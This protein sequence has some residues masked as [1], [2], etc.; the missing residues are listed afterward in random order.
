MNTEN[1]DEPITTELNNTVSGAIDESVIIQEPNIS[2]ITIIDDSADEGE[3]VD[4]SDEE[5]MQPQK[6]GDNADTL[7]KKR[8]IPIKKQLE[9]TTEAV[10]II[11]S[12]DE[13]KSRMLID[14]KFGNRKTYLA[15]QEEFITLFR[16]YYSKK[17]DD[18]NI[19]DFGISGQRI[20]VSERII[21]KSDSYLVDTTP[22]SKNTITEN[23]DSTPTYRKSFGEILLSG[24]A[25]DK[26]DEPS[27]K[28]N[29]Q[30]IC[31]N[32]GKDNH[33]LRD[34][35]EPRNMRKIN[36]S[37]NEFNKSNNRYHQD[38][39]NE[40][41]LCEPGKLSDDLRAALGISQTE[42][43]SHIYRMRELG[44]PP[45]W[46]EEAKI[47]HS[48]LSL[49]VE[50]DKRQLESDDDEGEVDA[51]KFKY[52]IQKIHDFP[53]FNVVPEYQFHDNYKRHR[54]QPMMNQHSK[55]EFIRLLGDSVV[56]GYKKIKLRD[57]AITEDYDCSKINANTTT[58]TETE[59]EIEDVEGQMTM[60][61]GVTFCQQPALPL[62]AK[63]YSILPPE[64]MTDEHEEGQL[65]D[66]DDDTLMTTTSLDE[67]NNQKQAL[68]A[69]I[70]DSSVFFDTSTIN[71]SVEDSLLQE[72]IDLEQDEDMNIT[73]NTTLISNIII[74]N[75][76]NEN[77]ENSSKDESNSNSI[78]ESPASP[79]TE[80]PASPIT[81]EVGHVESTVLGV[82]VL[83]SFT[84]FN[85]LPCG[86]NFS[87]GVCDVIAFENL[88]ES[89]GKYE[90][91][92]VLIDKVRGTLKK[93]NED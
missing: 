62:C 41:G 59:M 39:V 34:C 57:S 27:K 22:N 47:Q 13:Q 23:E 14:I 28:Q 17:L 77:L 38:A 79:I 50:K 66:C 71:T 12:G 10:E 6:V 53:G 37:R 46:L 48:G 7:E 30:C 40:Y 55:A 35:P 42:L 21:K 90:T 58:M 45:G 63:E 78:T 32:C 52:D 61:L 82:P 44:Y 43:P 92:K 65:I 91:M 74:E 3:L 67:L 31:F 87:K 73:S 19:C 83:P 69:E 20:C 60:P 24:D 25:S 76:V 9:T 26:K 80:S 1:T 49:F 15:F 29:R 33:Q 51:K 5:E 64:P 4:S 81:I 8:E 89:T 68:L 85:K 88:A 70:G 54:S 93:L 36:Q 72:I 86:E 16:K 2:V 11:G 18:L 75:S 84:P 56:N